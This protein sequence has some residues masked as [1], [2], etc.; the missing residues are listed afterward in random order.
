MHGKL[1]SFQ[2]TMLQWNEMHPYNAVHVARIPGALNPE[3]LWL[4]LS[5]TLERRG[6]THLVLDRERST[7]AYQGGPLKCDVKILA[8][9]GDPKPVLQAE[10]ERQLNTPFVQTQ[11]LSPF[12]FFT[13]PANGS[14]FLGLVYFHPVADAESIVFLFRDL[15]RAYRQ[16]A[17]LAAP[18]QWELYPDHRSHLLQRHPEVVARRLFALPGQVRRLKE[19]HR[20][21]Y[22][23]ALNLSNGFSLFSMK[24]EHLRALVAAGKSWSVTVN[25]LLL[26]LLMKSV[27][28]FSANRA[29][30]GRRRKLTVGCIVNLR[31]DLGIDSAR[32]FGLFLG[33]FTVTH[34]VP[35]GISLRELAGDIRRQTLGIK[36]HRLYLGT[37]LELGFG[38]FML[39]F[40]SPERRKKFYQKNY[41][42]W[43][44]IT[45][46]NLNSLWGPPDDD[47][48]M[49]Y[50]RGVST[51]PATP[52]V[53]SVTT[54]GDRANVGLSYRATVFTP[55][56][57]EQVRGNFMQDLEQLREVA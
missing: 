49:D 44:G 29:Q 27:S 24:P 26:A 32:M 31:R 22:R 11:E 16:Q 36:R 35:A 23:D 13:V 54:V 12:R 40:F 51:G 7:F 41:P 3:E 10:V 48:P 56:E 14:L 25:D 28:P 39:R 18:F 46:M 57:I 17:A 19:S 9:E 6:L 20:P 33:S 4:S 37:P 38:R 8:S 34:A 45:N 55:R 15:V 2:K 53:L 42:L 5:A 47:G 50:F 52:L 1:N 21:R 43:G 30:A